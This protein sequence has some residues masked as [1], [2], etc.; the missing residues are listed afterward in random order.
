MAKVTINVG[1]FRQV[2]QNTQNKISPT[3]IMTTVQI[4]AEA[5]RTKAQELTPV[6]TGALRASGD[7]IQYLQTPHSVVGEISFGGPAADYAIYVHE[8]LDV[9][10]E[11]GQAK[12]LEAAFGIQKNFVENLFRNLLKG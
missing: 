8:R 9:R 11:V 2:L 12:F 10:H 5:I 3:A 7:V 6:D 1:A 4:A